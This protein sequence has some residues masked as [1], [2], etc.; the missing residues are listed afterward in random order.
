LAC[1]QYHVIFTVP[2]DRNPL[3]PLHMPRMTGLIFQAVRAT[4]IERLGDATYLGAQPGMLAALHR[5]GRTLGWHP[6]VHGLVTGGGLTPSGEGGAGR[7]G[8]WLPVHVVTALFR[9]KFVGGLRRLWERGELTLPTAMRAQAFVNL[10]NRLGHAKKT[11][12]NVHI[13][14]RYRHGE[15][16]ATS[17]ARS[18]RGG[19]LKNEE[20]LFRRTGG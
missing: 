4:M 18:M 3:W 16:V 8:F 17:V 14:E 15:G 1:D 19:P 10:L 20:H 7:G 5:W 9:G 12:W 2:H 13:R 11:R 6:H